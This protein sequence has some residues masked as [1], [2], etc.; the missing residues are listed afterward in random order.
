MDANTH[1][2]IFKEEVFRIVGAALNVCNN[3]GCGF[4]EAVYQEAL[5]IEF[6][7]EQ[8]PFESQKPI[9]LK[10]KS[11]ILDKKYIADFLCFNSVIVEIKAK[12]NN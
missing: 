12:K 7:D 11:R 3:M 6:N 4:L 2:L 9:E 8:I 10:Y 5:E 1:E